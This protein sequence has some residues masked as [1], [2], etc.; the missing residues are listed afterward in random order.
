MQS[1][2]KTA[3]Q[4]NDT[5]RP[6]ASPDP[7]GKGKQKMTRDWAKEVGESSRQDELV[8]RKPDA[9]G[10][11]E[12]SW[13]SDNPKG[14]KGPASRQ[15]DRQTAG[16]NRRAGEMAPGDPGLQKA[17]KY[18]SLATM[19]LTHDAN[20]MP[21][22]VEPSVKR[23]WQGTN[24]MTGYGGGY[25]AQIDPSTS[26]GLDMADLM[27]KETAKDSFMGEYSA[28]A[29]KK[30]RGS[31]IRNVIEGRL[32]DESKVGKR[33]I[34]R[35]SQ[36]APQAQPVAQPLQPARPPPR[37]GQNVT[38]TQRSASCAV[39]RTDTHGTGDCPGGHEMRHGDVPIC[40]YCHTTSANDMRGHTFDTNEINTGRKD[41]GCRYIREVVKEYKTNV[42]ARKFLTEHLLVNRKG[43]GPVRAYRQ[44]NCFVALAL[45][46]SRRWC[47]GQMPED[48]DY[49]WPLT[50]ADAVRHAAAL[51]NW[52]NLAPDDRPRSS[53]DGLEIGEIC[54]RYEAGDIPPQIFGPYDNMLRGPSRRG[55]YDFSA[56][57]AGSRARFPDTVG[58]TAAA[59][60]QEA[61]PLNESVPADESLTEILNNRA[62]K[63]AQGDDGN[64][65]ELSSI[66]SSDTSLD[67]NLSQPV[68]ATEKAQG[69]EDVQVEED[70]IGY[71]DTAT[72]KLPSEIKKTRA[73]VLDEQSSDDDW[74]MKARK[75]T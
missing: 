42:D 52:D 49:V 20:D 69:A 27:M 46:I 13:N 67:L 55:P 19:N 34:K 39:C 47:D 65:S 14:Y 44:E 61:G 48:I 53:L 7:K 2:N 37:V 75:K 43:K 51:R 26:E 64:V 15:N 29:I 36:A 63:L 18:R 8:T 10:L 5:E 60:K 25:F 66:S 70:L 32:T 73:G 72:S 68:D 31:T 11:E 58:P 40:P 22:F 4:G 21:S 9:P 35:K 71:S 17:Q 56:L 45:E 28:P 23:T 24:V 6:Q 50:K 30:T 38:L 16:K 74:F 57:R 1:T 33:L 59:E 54:R 41:W 3:P 62:P 12:S